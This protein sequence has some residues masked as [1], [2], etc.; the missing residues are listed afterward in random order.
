MNVIRNG[1]GLLDDYDIIALTETWLNDDINDAELGLFNYN[2]IRCDR[3]LFSSDK[4]DGGGVLIALHKKFKFEKITTSNNSFELTFIKIFTNNSS[5]IIG[6]CYIPTGSKSEYYS[7]FIECLQTSLCDYLVSENISK[8]CL[9]GDFNIPGYTW[10]N[11]SRYSTAHGYH[12]DVNFREAAHIMSEWCK[13]YNMIQLNDLKNASDNILD[14]IFTNVY[15][16][17]STLSDDFLIKCDEAHHPLSI[18]FALSSINLCNCNDV[19][20]D[21]KHANFTEMSKKL[22]DIIIP[23]NISNEYQLNECVNNIE[24]I[25]LNLINEFVPTLKIKARTF[26]HWYS[27]DLKAAI[28]NKKISH[29]LYKRYNSQIFYDKFKKNRAYAKLLARRDEKLYLESTEESIRDN[30]KNFFKYVNNLSSNNSI[31]STVHFNDQTADNGQDIVN[32]FASKFRSI[33][34]NTDLSNTSLSFEFNDLINN[35]V[36]SLEDIESCIS[37][38][39]SSQSPGPDKI[40]PILIVNCNE[41]IKHW[42]FQLFNLSVKLGIFPQTWKI[43]FISPFFKGGDPFDVNNYRPINKYKVFAKMMDF[44]MYTKLFP[45]FRKYIVPHQHGFLESRSTITN[46][47]I[48]TNFIVSQNNVGKAVDSIYIDF[49][50]AFDLVNLNLLLKKLEAFGVFGNLLSWLE[51]FLKGRIQMV[52]IKNFISDI[53]D[54]LSGVGQGTHMGPLLFLIFINDIVKCIKYCEISL[55]ADDTKIFKSIESSTDAMKLQLD[56][57]SFENW[58][59]FNGLQCNIKKCFMIRFGKSQ[60]PIYDYFLGGNLLERVDHIRDLG[61]ILDSKLSYKFHIEYLNINVR[62]KIYFIKRFSFK[63]KSISTFR[64]I[65]FA[66]IYSKLMYASTIWSPTEKGEKKNLNL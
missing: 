56:I 59:N 8:F 22:K 24:L 21:Y 23:T 10:L 16:S 54:V 48:Y 26:P 20:L 32:L 29:K 19:I 4:K 42:L 60:Q 14:L 7:E 61:V 2:I 43:S 1:I 30:S 5:F 12:K 57:N 51:S 15:N 66:Y 49:T 18:S 53:I 63:F 41:A 37:N 45:Y 62:K 27:N 36:F 28:I 50:R 3:S 25:F 35:T 33:Y 52:K 6:V 44:L 40:H 38:L 17:K 65:Y 31:P 9:L 13:L 47:S 55:F 58:C 64:S 46:L 39:S 34:Q 11:N